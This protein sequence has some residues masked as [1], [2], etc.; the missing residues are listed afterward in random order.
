M[1]LDGV[2]HFV[3]RQLEPLELLGLVV[4]E[5]EEALLDFA[6]AEYLVRLLD[7]GHRHWAAGAGAYRYSVGASLGLV[8]CAVERFGNHLGTLVPRR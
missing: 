4:V 1:A 5:A 3:L 2:R 8:F 6:V 7:F